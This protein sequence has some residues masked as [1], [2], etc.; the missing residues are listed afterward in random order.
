MVAMPHYVD[1]CRLQ[2]MIHGT[3]RSTSSSKTSQT[4]A[5]SMS[6]SVAEAYVERKKKGP[7]RRRTVQNG[8]KNDGKH[9]QLN[10]IIFFSDFG[11]ALANFLFIRSACLGT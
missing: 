6:Q 5:A 11:S 7:G 3:G 10:A 2:Q 8:R 1:R 4:F 9:L